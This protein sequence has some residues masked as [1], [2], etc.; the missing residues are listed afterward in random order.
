MYTVKWELNPNVTCYLSKDSL[1]TIW[2]HETLGPK[3]VYS[4]AVAEEIVSKTH[5]GGK[6]TIIEVDY[7]PT[8]EELEDKLKALEAINDDI[9]SSKDLK[10]MQDGSLDLLYVQ[11]DNLKEEIE[12]LKHLLKEEE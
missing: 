11:R 1:G 9:E 4:K 6:L 10:I 5:C 7:K 2:T 8:K 3:C 12:I